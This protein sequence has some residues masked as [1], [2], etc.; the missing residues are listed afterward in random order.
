[1]VA[2]LFVVACTLPSFQFGD[3][4]RPGI[5]GLVCGCVT[6]FPWLPNPL[7]FF[8]CRALLAGQ[9]RYAF[10]LGVVACF[11]ALSIFVVRDLWGSLS[12]G[13]YVWQADIVLFTVA[14]GVL[15]R[16]HG[17]WVRGP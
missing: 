4:Y 8:G 16:R 3:D 5:F 10:A 14:A 12:A 15:W 17:A 1:M 9:N 13:Y 7:L 6:I 11:C 2:V